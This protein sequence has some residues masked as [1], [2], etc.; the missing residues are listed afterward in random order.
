MFMDK[1]GV[2][3]FEKCLTIASSCNL[4]YRKNFLKKDTIA[5]IPPNG[6]RQKD[7]QSRI[8]INW[9]LW[10]ERTTGLTIRHAFNNSEVQIGPYK[11]DGLCQETNTIYEFYG[12]FWHGCPKCMFQRNKLTADKYMTAREAYI[13]TMERQKYLQDQGYTIVDK[14]ECDL[15][16]DMEDNSDMKDFFSTLKHMDPLNPRN[17]KHSCFIE[18]HV[19]VN[20]NNI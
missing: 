7:K 16:R 9:L 15:I 2:D 20:L 6:Y 14:W 10:L 17:G 19:F 18:T 3:P 8:A 11:V 5:I 13:R 1:T 12:C 4:A